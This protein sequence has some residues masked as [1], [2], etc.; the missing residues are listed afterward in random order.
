MRQVTIFGDDEFANAAAE[1]TSNKKMRTKK[2]EKNA[3]GT[4]FDSNL[5]GNVP[6]IKNCTKIEKIK[7][8]NEIPDFPNEIP[9]I[10]DK[11]PNKDPNSGY[12]QKNP[13]EWSPC[14]VTICTKMY[15]YICNYSRFEQKTQIR[16]Y[17][18]IS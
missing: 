9:E 12:V 11:T 2:F 3:D 8:L 5:D 4:F 17:F 15:I 16:V 13:D 1:K 18:I 6:K 7:W 10:P 14:R